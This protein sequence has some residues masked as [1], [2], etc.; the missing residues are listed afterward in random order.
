M[1]DL[2]DLVSRRL[3]PFLHTTWNWRRRER[4][5][6]PTQARNELFLKSLCKKNIMQQKHRATEGPFNVE[7]S[8][9]SNPWLKWEK[10]K[11]NH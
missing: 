1:Q 3:Y 8:D 6:L 9:L 5:G 7:K 11:W 4:G 2:L 10:V